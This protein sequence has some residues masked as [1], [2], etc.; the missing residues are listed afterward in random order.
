MSKVRGGKKR[1]LIEKKTKVKGRNWKKE[2][3]GRRYYK[4]G[5]G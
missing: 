4:V 1:K 3:Y 5:G 2:N